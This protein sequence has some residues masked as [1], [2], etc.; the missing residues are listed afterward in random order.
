MPAERLVEE[1]VTVEA[2]PT[3]T[4]DAATEKLVMLGK[5]FTLTEGVLLICWLHKLVVFVANT[6]N[7]VVLERLPVGKLRLAPLP[8]MAE[9]IFTLP[10]LFRS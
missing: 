3:P 10:V 9:P 6:L 7:V 2:L 4:F 8:T 5:A 1:T